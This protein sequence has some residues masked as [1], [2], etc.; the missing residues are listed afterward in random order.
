[1]P[2]LDPYHNDG[3]AGLTIGEPNMNA[4]N[5]CPTETKP[6]SLVIRCVN[7]AG[8]LLPSTVLALMPKC[9]LCMAA[10][11]A[12]A[13]GIC[14]SVSAASYL[15]TGLIVLCIASLLFLAARQ[16]HRFIILALTSSKLETEKPNPSN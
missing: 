3:L 7:I 6:P 12:I 4:S 11:V 14:I 9:P 2:R 5:C 13:S 15:R 8:W 1:M 16:I 10:Y